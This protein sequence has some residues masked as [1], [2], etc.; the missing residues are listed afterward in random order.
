[1]PHIDATVTSSHGVMARR[2]F[3]A[4]LGGLTVAGIAGA[5][6]TSAPLPKPTFS[7]SSVFDDGEIV[8]G[9]MTFESPKGHGEGRGYLVRPVQLKRELPAVLVAHGSSGLNPYAKAV[10]HRLARQGYL[11]FAP[12]ALHASGGYPGDDNDG[13][14][15]LDAMDHNK[16]DQDFVM[17]AEV[18][19][20]HELSNGKL[21]VV[22]F[23]FGGYISN[24]LASRPDLVDA[25]VPFYGMPVQNER[26]DLIKGPL[27]LQFAG[28]DDWVNDSWEAYEAVLRTNQA[29]Y[30][31]FIY[32]DVDYDFH[33][34]SGAHYHQGMADLAWSRTLG[35]L[36]EH[37][38]S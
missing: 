35:F 8:G 33:D 5:V 1:M 21:G 29:D 18:L 34:A 15:L 7:E 38:Q 3:L 4:S 23:C 13:W 20:N 32:P 9:Y 2:T 17:A 10:A 11:A 19:K 26:A 27:L 16:V 12:D 24:L 28:L 14:S 25:S 30:R 31:A 22:G 6:I 36:G 37:L